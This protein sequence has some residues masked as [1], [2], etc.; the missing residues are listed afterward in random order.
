MKTL[1]ALSQTPSP[2]PEECC[3]ADTELLSALAKWVCWQKHEEIWMCFRSSPRRVLAG[4]LASFF[5]SLQP[6]LLTL[7]LSFWCEGVWDSPELR[8]RHTIGLAKKFVQVLLY[9]LPEE[10][11]RTFW[12]TQYIWLTWKGPHPTPHTPRTQYLQY[13]KLPGSLEENSDFLKRVQYRW[14]SPFANV[15][16]GGAMSGI[17]RVGWE[18][19]FQP[20][21]LSWGQWSSPQAWFGPRLSVGQPQAIALRLLM[22]ALFA[23]SRSH[24][25]WKWCCQN[26]GE[27]SAACSSFSPSSTLLPLLRPPSCGLSADPHCSLLFSPGWEHSH[28]FTPLAPGCCRGRLRVRLPEM[29]LVF[30]VLPGTWGSESERPGSGVFWPELLLGRRRG[31][32]SS[33]GEW[34]FQSSLLWIL[35]LPVLTFTG[36]IASDN[37]PLISSLPQHVH[38]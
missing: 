33:K 2:L 9:Q 20:P 31:Y 4:L 17:L 21:G 34:L 30:I 22:S 37:W 18:R 16:G 23:H 14:L 10:S 28:L 1:D 27:P 25:C 8:Q 11:E 5:P 24:W 36:D 35:K 19:S 26:W 38:Q 13:Q 3:F 12:P 7:T 15:A 32:C 29:P 6:P